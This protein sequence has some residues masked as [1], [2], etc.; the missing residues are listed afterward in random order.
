MQKEGRAKFEERSA[1]A[2][3]LGEFLLS[4]CAKNYDLRTIAGK[5]QYLEELRPYLDKI[6]QGA[7]R[8]LMEE[9]LAK[10]LS[11][12]SE[13]LNS[14]W[15]QTPEQKHNKIQNIK[16]LDNFERALALLLA[17]PHLAQ[18]FPEP[19]WH[20]NYQQLEVLNEVWQFCKTTQ[21]AHFG[22]IQAN[23]ET[24]EFKDKLLQLMTHSYTEMIKDPEN[25]FH[26]ILQKL[27]TKPQENRLEQ[28]MN[29]ARQG[30]LSAEEKAEM[31]ELLKR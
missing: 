20:A 21:P 5:S 18:K 13:Q 12:M 28:L 9:S 23:F 2:K 3:P 8:M 10:R 19:N 4:E 16:N 24:T 1:R 26:D 6:P 22:V 29:Q 31:M 7:Y 30:E 17:H 11:L 15:G 25:E 14:L 27:K